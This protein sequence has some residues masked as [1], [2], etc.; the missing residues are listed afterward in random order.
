M[1]LIE[2]ETLINLARA[3]AGEC[4][5]MVRYKFI[6]YGARMQ[7]MKQLAQII[8]QLGYNEFNHARMF[9]TKIQDA[10]K[11]TIDNIEISAGFPFKEKWDLEDNLRLAAEDELMEAE[12][13]YPHFRDVARAE[14]FEEI[15]T[16]FD[17]VIQVEHKHH[18]VLIK[19]Y[20]QLHNDSLYSKPKETIWKCYDC[21]YEEN[22]S[23]A[24]ES[25]PLCNA[26]Q[27]SVVLHLD[28]IK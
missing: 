9:Y 22:T 1:K 25:C 6:E 8:D 26:K 28:K 3:Y 10:S 17:R 2:S 12:T 13:I 18:D 16:L 21:G 24:W 14:G 20:D 7:E 23:N 11:D 4:Q 19:L 5:A 27:G 15:A